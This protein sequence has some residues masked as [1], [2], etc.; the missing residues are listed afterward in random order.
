MKSLN[1]ESCQKT[2]KQHRPTVAH[3][4]RKQ[5]LW[6][7]N[8]EGQYHANQGSTLHESGC[9]DHVCADIAC[10]FRLAC[11]TFYC[12]TTDLTDTKTCADYGQTCTNCC[13]HNALIY[14]E[15]RK[16]IVGLGGIRN[17]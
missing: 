15:L 10:C 6:S 13:V 4:S 8:E 7:G 9:Q 3:V 11:N 2:G 5:L 17:F 16:F 1:P 14:I 12:F